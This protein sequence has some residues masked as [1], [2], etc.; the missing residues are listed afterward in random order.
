LAADLA[1]G[2]VG[3]AA[4]GAAGALMAATVF[5]SASVVPVVAESCD[6]VV[7]PATRTRLMKPAAV[8]H[9]RTSV[10][11]QFRVQ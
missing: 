7:H 8:F 1:A 11:L 9:I 5:V 3:L 6:V 10:F 4:D 2:V